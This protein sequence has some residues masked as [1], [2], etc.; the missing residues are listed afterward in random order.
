ME[1][2]GRKDYVI[3]ITNVEILKEIVCYLTKNIELVEA[4]EIF[5]ETKSVNIRTFDENVIKEMKKILKEPKDLK[6]E[7][8]KTEEEEST[9]RE[10][11]FLEVFSKANKEFP[12]TLGETLSKIANTEF[13]WRIYKIA[14]GKSK[15]QFHEHIEIYFNSHKDRRIFFDKEKKCNKIVFFQKED[16][17]G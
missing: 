11:Y 1:K 7:K 6:V 14:F 2:T 13:F 16:E 5:P 10:L 4:F 12:K 8:V 3:E 15:K 9:V 17:K